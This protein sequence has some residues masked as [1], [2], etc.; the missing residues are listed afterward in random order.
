MSTHEI[1]HFHLFGGLGGGARGFNRGAAIAG[2]MGRTMLLAWS[3]Q[4][5]QM[6]LA[7]V[8]VR[9]TLAGLMV[10]QH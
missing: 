8:W 5:A 1:R 3:G 6:S 2:E 9:P 10:A 4:T 7:P